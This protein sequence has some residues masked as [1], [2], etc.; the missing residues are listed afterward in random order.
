MLGMDDN[1]QAVLRVL[2]AILHM[3]NLE[4]VTTEQGTARIESMAG[5]QKTTYFFH[6]RNCTKNYFCSVANSL[7]YFGDECEN[8][9]RGTHCSSNY[10][11]E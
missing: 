11:G 9:R 8:S 3:G 5:N 1:V 7:R 2:A 10:D 6:M 4:F